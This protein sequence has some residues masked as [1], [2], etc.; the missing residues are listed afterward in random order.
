VQTN[1]ALVTFNICVGVS[2]NV[3]LL[4]G[5]VLVSQRE[6][7]LYQNLGISGVPATLISILVLDLA[8]YA[9]HVVLH[10]SPFL[11]RVHLV[12]HNDVTVDATTSYR[13]HPIEPAFR[14]GVTAI[15][16]WGLGVPPAALALYRTLSAVNAILEHANIRVPRLID[17]ALIWFWVTPDM[18]KIHHSRLQS[19]TDSNYANLFAFYDRLFGTFTPTAVAPSVSYGIDG[20]E[21]A[22]QQTMMALLRLPFEKDRRATVPNPSAIQGSVGRLN[23]PP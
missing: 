15:V 17:R 14:W 21:Q 18:H 22:A 16:A 7:G 19:Q 23:S 10:K 3:V 1:L 8:A 5:A 9:A 2:L 12:H 4:G 11:W 20:H 6:W 13:H